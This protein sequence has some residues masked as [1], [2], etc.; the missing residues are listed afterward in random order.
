M[1]VLWWT[2]E[3]RSTWNVVVKTEMVVVYVWTKHLC[4]GIASADEG[5]TATT[6]TQPSAWKLFGTVRYLSVGLL[7]QLWVTTGWCVYSC[8][9]QTHLDLLNALHLVADILWLFNVIK[10]LL[11]LV[12]YFLIVCFVVN[13]TFPVHHFGKL[14]YVTIQRC[15][16]TVT[17]DHCLFCNWVFLSSLLW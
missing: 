13:C 15:L 10:I 7:F 9:K 12:C 11:T 3:S 17:V 4:G 5:N 2:S 14:L 1:R 16:Y 6:S 8:S